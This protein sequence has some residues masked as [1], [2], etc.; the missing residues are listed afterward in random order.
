VGGTFTTQTCTGATSSCNAGTCTCSPG[1]RTCNG[2]QVLECS[3]L[4]Q[5]VPIVL[6]NASGELVCN[7][8]AAPVVRACPGAAGG[9]PC[10]SAGCNGGACTTTP[11]VGA[12]CSGGGL[13]GSCD[14]TGQCCTAA[15]GEGFD[16]GNCAILCATDAA[17]NGGRCV[18]GV[19]GN[20]VR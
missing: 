4:G 12:A 3:A 10:V 13:A 2:T 16:V 14:N 8:G 6:C 18:N 11:N 15:D 9:N 5:Q 19:C 17:C 7:G 20:Q 1:T